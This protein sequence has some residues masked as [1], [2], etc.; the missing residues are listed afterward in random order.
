L[1]R[2]R[3]LTNKTAT[4][5]TKDVNSYENNKKAFQT[6]LL[7]AKLLTYCWNSQHNPGK[8]YIFNRRVHHGEIGALLRLSN[9]FK[10]SK[11][12]PTGILSGIGEGLAKDDYGDRE[13]W[14]T[15]KKNISPE[16]SKNRCRDQDKETT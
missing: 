8:T 3:G 7:I 14:F 13:E 4:K 6:G 10:K 9:L 11:P 2:N 5:A 1:F 12:I 16:Q 15:F